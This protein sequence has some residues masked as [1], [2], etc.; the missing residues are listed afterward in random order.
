MIVLYFLYN[1]FK[2]IVQTFFLVLEDDFALR[3]VNIS[4]S[5]SNLFSLVSVQSFSIN[6]NVFF[7]SASVEHYTQRDALLF[8]CFA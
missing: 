6:V 2:F 1:T 5:S 8:H 4:S 3:N 7:I